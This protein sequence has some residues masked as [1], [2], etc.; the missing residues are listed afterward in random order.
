VNSFEKLFSIV[1]D[2]ANLDTREVMIA[3]LEETW[4]WWQEQRRRVKQRKDL[5]VVKYKTD[6]EV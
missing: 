3:R 6:R 5:G 1:C 4:Q 2:L